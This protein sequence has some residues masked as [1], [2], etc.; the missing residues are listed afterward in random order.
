MD[1]RRFINTIIIN[2]KIYYCYY[3][4]NPSQP[5]KTVVQYLVSPL[6]RGTTGHRGNCA[7]AHLA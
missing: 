6:H 5:G 3:Y 4:V 7:V 2:N 1:I